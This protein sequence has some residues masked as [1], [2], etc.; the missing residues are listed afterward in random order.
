MYTK[1]SGEEDKQNE[2]ITPYPEIHDK[3]SDCISLY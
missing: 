1:I 3:H 2:S